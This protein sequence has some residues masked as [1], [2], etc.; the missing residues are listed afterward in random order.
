MH[1]ETIRRIVAELED[2]LTGRFLGKI[3]QLSSLSLA[4][5][6]GLRDNSYLF[7]S[8]EPAGPQL[9]LIKRRVRDLEKQSI[10]HQLFAQALRSKLAGGRVHSILKEP[11]ERVVRF[12][13][14]VT[15]ETGER[16]ERML[17]AQLTGRS[18]NLFLVDSDGLIMHALRSPRGV[19]QQV[20]DVYQPP[21]AIS[22]K[23]TEEE[24]LEQG[25][26]DS[27]SAAADDHY[28]RLEKNRAFTADARTAQG[29]LRKEMAHREKLRLNLS[30]DLAAHGDA[31]KH[32]RLGEL[33]LA[34][35]ETAERNG[36]RVGI[37]DYYADGEPRIELEIDEN[38]TL[39]EEAASYF[40]RYTRARRAAEEIAGRLSEIDRELEELRSREAELERIVSQQDE[41]A[42]EVLL[43]TK[44]RET[45]KAKK[46]TKP[47]KLPGIRRYR[48]SDDFEVLVGRAARDNDYLTFKVARPQDVWLHCA[49]YPGSHVVIRNPDRKEVPH[50]TIIE[51]GQLAAKFSQASGDSKVTI[52]YTQR[53]F[54]AKPKGAAPGLVRM[55]SFRSLTV[56][57]GENIERI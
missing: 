27:L 44:R 18:A 48:S 23:V 52:H 36:S 2:A 21:P 38:R 16:H 7:I 33:L 3:F 43:G 22:G 50:R 10:Q 56:A 49:D 4:I 20:G 51:A 35:I 39:Q 47:E 24:Q 13:L 37:T 42:L 45:A 55:S 14:Q 26:F 19:G 32:R 17:V 30:R 9:Y 31:G 1:Q 41:G 34:N 6:F 46:K 25:G 40:A 8:V 11:T 12:N 15:E 53:K 57:P 28:Q 54:L 29:R 5:D